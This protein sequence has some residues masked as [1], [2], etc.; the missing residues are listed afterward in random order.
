MIFVQHRFVVPINVEQSFDL[1]SNPEFDPV[2]QKS[3]LEAKV[4]RALCEAEGIAG[5][6]THY[7]IEFSFLGKHMPFRCLMDQFCYPNSFQF[8]TVSGPFDY[9]GT[10]ILMPVAGSVTEAT[11]VHWQ[12]WVDPKSF[13]GLVPGILLEKTL[14]SQYQKDAASLIAWVEQA[15][16]QSLIHCRRSA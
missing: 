6:V 3:C 15:T 10:Y 9:R 16:T 1:L 14:L 11:T 5:A 13:F 7:D 8:R 2:W 12:F 4:D